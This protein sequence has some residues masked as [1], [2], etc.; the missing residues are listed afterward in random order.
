MI[1]GFLRDNP[2]K[3]PSDIQELMKEMMRQV[4]QGGL[5]VELDEE[6]G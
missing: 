6:L 4:L 2:I 3:D 1:E 5:A